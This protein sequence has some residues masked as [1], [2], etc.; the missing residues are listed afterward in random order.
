MPDTIIGTETWLSEEI[1]STDFYNLSLGC[2]V[3]RRDRPN[4]TH[5][6]LLLAV[7]NDIEVLDV[8][9]HKELALASGTIKVGNKTMV[10]TSFY[11]PPDKVD[12]TYFDD[13]KQEF[14][15]LKT[16]FNRTIFIIGGDFNIPDID[17]I[18]NTATDTHNPQRVSQTFL[19]IAMDLGLKQL[20][21]FPIR[22]QK[23]A[24]LDIDITPK[25]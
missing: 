22:P 11:R 23:Y 9:R 24:Q 4:D 5:W 1:Q 13:V 2:R 6:G 14:N 20:V 15:R 25:L 18:K 12:Q 10:I 7:P 17:W 8:I 21:R 16:K 19:D 3:C